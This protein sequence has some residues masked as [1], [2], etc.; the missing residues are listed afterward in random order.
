MYPHIEKPEGEPARLRRVPRVRV[1]QVVMDYL[2]H[3]WSVDEICRQHPY[4]RSAEAHAAMAFYFDHQAEI[5]KEIA[6]E[7]NEVDRLRA[8]APPASLVVR[9]KTGDITGPPAE[10]KASQSRPADCQ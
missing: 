9:E 2:A 5:D 1:A 10:S 8:C 3:G 4:L 6:A 7:L